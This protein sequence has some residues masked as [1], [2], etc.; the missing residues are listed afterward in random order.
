MAV[1]SG[2]LV[3]RLLQRSGDHGSNSSAEVEVSSSLAT[4]AKLVIPAVGVEKVLVVDL[5]DGL[6]CRTLGDV[7]VGRLSGDHRRPCGWRAQE[8]DQA[9]DVLGGGGQ[10]ELLLNELQPAQPET[11]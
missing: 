2:R 11:L 7:G 1:K 5:A 4:A 9:F 3:D 8:S 6:H 10:E